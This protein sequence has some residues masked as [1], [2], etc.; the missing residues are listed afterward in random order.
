MILF[1]HADTVLAA[2]WR[3]A[4]ERA[5]SDPGCAG[6]AFS[7]RFATRG[8]AEQWV[9]R[10]AALRVALF[11]LPYGDQAI[12]LRREVLVEMGGVPSVPIM[13]DLDLVR[14]IKRAGR[15]EILAL[16]AT[17]S[18]RRYRGRGTLRTICW[19]QVALLGWL[20]GWNRAWLAQRMGR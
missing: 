7:L 12:F 13:E 20:L 19:H 16:A 2:G 10:W 6:G 15:I 9:E 14:A 5:L 4:V 3:E 1:L 8:G 11:D 18:S 17:T